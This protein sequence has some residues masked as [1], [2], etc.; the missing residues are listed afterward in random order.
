[1]WPMTSVEYQNVKNVMS[2]LLL[3]FNTAETIATSW[4]VRLVP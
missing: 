1:M 2:A 4:R 3:T